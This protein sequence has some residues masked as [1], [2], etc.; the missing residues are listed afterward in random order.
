MNR[1]HLP[2]AWMNISL[3]NLSFFCRD[4]ERER[5]RWKQSSDG[6]I[7]DL[8]YEIF[9]LQL[10]NFVFQGKGLTTVIV[11]ECLPRNGYETELLATK[12][13]LEEAKENRFITELEDKSSQ[14]AKMPSCKK[15][16]YFLITCEIDVFRL[17]RTERNY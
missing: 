15:L 6:I 5:L 8:M 10:A 11:I 13:A 4:L 16:N 1:T 12:A 14:V 17:W 3:F 7:Y 9:F 2:F